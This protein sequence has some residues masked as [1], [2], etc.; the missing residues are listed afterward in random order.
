MT[1]PFVVPAPDFQAEAGTIEGDIGVALTSAEKLAKLRPVKP[2]GTVSFGGQTH[3]ADGNVG[4]L[5]ASP[6]RARAL[7]RDTGV[8]VR[9][10]GFGQARVEARLHAGGAGSCGAPST[11][12]GRGLDCAPRGDQSHNPFAVNDLVF[13]KETCVDVGSM[14]NFGCSLIWGRSAGPTGLRAIV[15]LIEELA[16]RGGGLGLFQGC[17]AGN[18]AMAVVIEVSDWKARAAMFLR[19]RWYAAG[20][21]REVGRKPLGRTLC[22]EPVV[23]YRRLDGSVVAMRDACPHRL[24][25]LSMGLL[26][27]DAIRCRYHGMKFDGSGRCV[28]MPSQPRLAETFG[29][30]SYPVLERFRFVWVWIG[31][32]DKADPALLPNFWPC[33]REGWTFDGGTYHLKAAYRL[34]ID[35]LMD[36]SHETYVH[37]GSIGQAEIL[38]SPIEVTAEGDEVFVTRWMRDIEAPPFWRYALKQPGRVDRWQI[39]RFMPPSAVMIM[40]RR[41][42]GGDGR[43][44]GGPIPRRERLRHRLHD[45]RDGDD[46]LVFLGHGAQLRHRGPGLHRP[47]QGAAG[48]GVPG[49]SRRSSRPSSGQS[50]RIRK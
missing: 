22:G 19:N 50:T 43:A 10:R 45:T 6:E 21:D 23:L 4:L 20:W 27:G 16:L 15:E 38:E 2:G 14:N 34:M 12:S 37:A 46:D 9:L 7:A 36:L 31:E 48:R 1:L 17:A 3:P 40:C 39:C 11:G 49:G 47:L 5:L 13:A 8:R 29:V 32:P 44:R 26:E 30:P 28:E 35:N 25:P 24:L 33:E 42:A 41:G 18:S